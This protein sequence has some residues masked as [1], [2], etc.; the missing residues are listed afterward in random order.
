MNSSYS[1]E[2]N[3]S[4]YDT[5]GIYT[6]RRQDQ[7]IDASYPRV[8]SLVTVLYAALVAAFYAPI[9]VALYRIAR[10]NATFILFLSHGIVDFTML[11]IVNYRYVIHAMGYDELVCESFMKIINHIPW[12]NTLLHVLLI[13]VNRGHSM[14]FPL[15]Y[16]RVWTRNFCIASVLSCWLVSGTAIAV[17]ATATLVLRRFVLL[18]EVYTYFFRISMYGSV[19]IY[20]SVMV[21]SAVEK[22]VRLVL[23]IPSTA[24]VYMEKGRIRL[25]IYCFATFLPLVVYYGIPGLFYGMNTSTQAGRFRGSLLSVTSSLLSSALLYCMSSLVRDNTPLIPYLMK[26]G[27]VKRRPRV[28]EASAGRVNLDESGMITHVYM[29]GEGDGQARRETNT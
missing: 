24:S 11:S 26:C 12:M 17:I 6:G 16:T 9:L 5:C 15:S 23:C 25:F 2:S 14:H 21:R 29:A 8:Y 20:V 4:V 27:C 10:Q 28:G 22:C 13:A 19:A 1:L 7:P 3:F 18:G